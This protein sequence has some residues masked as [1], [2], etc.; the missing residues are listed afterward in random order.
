MN[1][2]ICLTQGCV[3]GI[4]FSDIQPKPFQKILSIFFLYLSITVSSSDDTNALR[5]IHNALRMI[6]NALRMIQLLN[7]FHDFFH[8]LHHKAT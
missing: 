3:V 4:V 6:H 1:A 2:N 8:N 5:T 7:Q